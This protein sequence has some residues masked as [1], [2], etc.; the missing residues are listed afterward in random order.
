MFTRRR[1]TGLFVAVF[2]FALAVFS[3]VP[4]DASPITYAF[5]TFDGITP[6]GEGSFTFD[7]SLVPLGEVLY[8]NDDFD[9]TAFSYTDPIVDPLGTT[10]FTLAELVT[11]QFTFSPNLPVFDFQVSDVN[12]TRLLLGFTTA[13]ISIGPPG[14]KQLTMVGPRGD[15]PGTDADSRANLAAAV[16]H[17]SRRRRAPR[18]SQPPPVAG[19]GKIRARSPSWHW[20]HHAASASAF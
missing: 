11:L 9:V 13:A 2:M 18:P 3:A 5:R 14:V 8:D 17:R 6:F 1:R 19:S 16:R 10:P 12:A 20:S 4:A 7:D 15:R